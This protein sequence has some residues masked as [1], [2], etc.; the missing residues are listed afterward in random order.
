[1]YFLN[2]VVACLLYFL[3]GVFLSF[4][5]SF[6]VGGAEEHFATIIILSPLALITIIFS[7]LI[8][9]NDTYLCWEDGPTGERK[10]LWKRLKVSLFFTLF[11]F[12]PVI[13]NL[14]SIVFGELGYYKA[15]KFAFEYR[16]ETIDVVLLAVV[17][18][19]VWNLLYDISKECYIKAR[20]F[21]TKKFT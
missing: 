18:F 2:K 10:N 13:A 6:L 16:F 11:W 15:S 12:L 5:Y 7:A 3:L 20:K 21:L 17:A 8:S 19:I 4:I 1:M 9:W 14:V